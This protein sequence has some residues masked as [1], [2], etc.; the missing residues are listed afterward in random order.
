M[1]EEKQNENHMDMRYDMPAREQ[2]RKE[3]IGEEIQLQAVCIRD[4]REKTW[5]QGK[6]CAASSK[7]LW[8]RY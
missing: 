5:I 8:W 1:H 2:Y 4:K 3:E 7:C 6:S